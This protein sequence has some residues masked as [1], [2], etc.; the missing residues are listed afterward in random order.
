MSAEFKLVPQIL[1]SADRSAWGADAKE[2]L[3]LTDGL[4]IRS[5]GPW[6]EKKHKLLTFY[7]HLFA[8]GMKNRWPDRVY[9]ELFSGPG[10]CLIRGTHEEDLGSPL[11]VIDHDFTKFIF[12]ERRLP[13]ATALA[14]RLSNHPRRARVEILCGDCAEAVKNLNIPGNALTLA[15][16]D[17]T[18]IAH[19]PFSLIESL[20]TYSKTDLL[21]NIQHG[22]GIKMNMHQYT[23]DSEN[24][25]AL[26]KFL[27][28]D[29][30]KSLP[31]NHPRDFFLG[32]LD[33]YKERLVRMGYKAIGRD[34]L[35]KTERNLAL[36]LLLFASK[37]PKG[38]E[39]WEKSRKAVEDPELL[40]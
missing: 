12:I 16:I 14:E 13:A 3:S 25:S 28:S 39:F 22:M 38:T 8:T 9:L 40:L 1:R 37:N 20:Q 6:I 33:L 10:R 23:D 15:F 24:S 21:I 4:P 36:Y 7:G 32:V 18:G 27:G 30:W 19:A 35:I 34:V 31:R 11:K 2:P 17:P 29:D 26:T 5:S